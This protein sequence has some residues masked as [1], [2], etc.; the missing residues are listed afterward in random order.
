MR[1]K[2]YF[3]I[4]LLI[5]TLTVSAQSPVTWGELSQEEIK[6]TQYPKD[7][8]AAAVVLS[9]YGSISLFVDSDD[10]VGYIF[11]R[12]K[13][14]K[15]LSKSGLDYADVNIPYY[16]KDNVQDKVFDIR[17]QSFS[18]GKKTELPQNEVFTNSIN[19]AW[20]SID[21]SI[22]NVEE[23]SI[24]EYQYT[25]E[26]SR[27]HG[28]T[29]WY[30]Q[31]E[32]PVKSSLLKLQFENYFNFIYFVNQQ[33]KLQLEEKQSSIINGGYDSTIEYK[34]FFKM[35]DLPAIE[36]E[37]YVT[38]IENYI[39]KVQ[40]QL[41]EFNHSNY[42][43]NTF[44][45]D[46]DE[47]AYDLYND[48]NFGDQYRLKKHYKN[49][50]AAYD[51][52][53][54]ASTDAKERMLDIYQ[55][56]LTN[57]SWN[58]KYR[59]MTTASLDDAFEKKKANSATLNFMFI[60]LLKEEG[61]LAYPALLSTRNNGHYIKSHPIMDQFNHVISS[62]KIDDKDYL[63]DVST[64]HYPYNLLPSNDLNEEACVLKDKKIEWQKI[65]SPKSLTVYQYKVGFY[66]ESISTT[67]NAY[68]KGYPAAYYRFV[69]KEK[70]AKEKA[71]DMLVEGF[72]IS[73]LD[74]KNQEKTDQAFQL[75]MKLENEK[76]DLD[77][78]YIYVSPFIIKDFFDLPFKQD[79]RIYPVEFASPNAYQYSASIEIPEGFEVEELP[80]N[81]RMAIPEKSMTM[82]YFAEQ[83]EDRIDIVFKHNINVITYPSEA[84]PQLKEFYIKMVEKLG[85]Q[86]VFKR[87]D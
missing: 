21:F 23:G 14:I 69:S 32:I 77:Q 56:I 75:I 6:M 79:Q 53:R 43:R 61:I 33:S 44:L 9:D 1:M 29:P 83:M 41:L 52:V 51:R 36:E 13:R 30:F 68:F 31:E 38:T 24:I 46:W 60:A 27:I 66:S 59:I 55:F 16:Q 87:K 71:Q 35:E 84:Y 64:I 63:I 15:I 70:S 62:V 54:K 67:L 40:F 37:A 78:S 49:L 4:L 5:L 48:L 80:V 7:T 22:P 20:K 47:M 50:K 12:H 11:R 57:V 81:M 65:V 72:S 58:G 18:K 45:K 76:I 85:E 42:G 17:A 25:I 86:I 2:V 39:A 73:A 82:T 8:I 19:S 74:Y 3:S 34:L 26:S 28:L 10:G